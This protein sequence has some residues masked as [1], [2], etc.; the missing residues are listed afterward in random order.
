MSSVPQQSNHRA[1]DAQMFGESSRLRA[2]A[3]LLGRHLLATL[4]LIMGLGKLAAAPA[5]TAYMESIGLPG[6]LLPLAVFVEIAGAIA[7]IIGW[8]TRIVSLVL[9]MFTLLTAALFHSNFGD[10]I[11]LVMFLKNVSIAGG[12]LILAANGPARYS[13]DARRKK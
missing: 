8:H 13:I 3:E 4:F 7:V 5:T 6:A 2:I 11:E 10:Q 9:A 1:V 12:F